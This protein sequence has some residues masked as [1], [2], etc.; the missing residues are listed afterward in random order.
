VGRLSPGHSAEIEHAGAR[1]HLEIEYVGIGDGKAATSAWLHDENTAL[2]W[3]PAEPCIQ[4]RMARL[5]EEQ[6]EI[7]V[8]FL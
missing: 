1:S 3:K 4:R 8:Y 2:E 7:G 6:S 5:A